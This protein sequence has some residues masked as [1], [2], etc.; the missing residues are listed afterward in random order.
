[1]V[2]YVRKINVVDGRAQW[3]RDATGPIPYA[4]Q[5]HAMAVCCV[6]IRDNPQWYCYPVEHDPTT[7][8]LLSS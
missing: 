8:V 5:R 3:V 6:L 4:S 1:M 7:E 2:W